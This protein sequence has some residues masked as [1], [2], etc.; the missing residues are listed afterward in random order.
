MSVPSTQCNTPI[1]GESFMSHYKVFY[2]KKTSCVEEATLNPLEDIQVHN[3]RDKGIQPQ[4]LFL[5]DC[6]ATHLVKQCQLHNN[7]WLNLKLNLL[8][9]GSPSLMTFQ[10]VAKIKT[11]NSVVMSRTWLHSYFWSIAKTM[12]T[13]VLTTLWHCST[14]FWRQAQDLMRL[15]RL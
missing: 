3:V 11:R 7:P 13:I 14:D 15:I 1:L 2:A 12:S 6:E 4:D 5:A 9:T 8:A 10:C